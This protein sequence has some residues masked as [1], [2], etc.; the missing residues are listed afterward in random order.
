LRK[1]LDESRDQSY[2]LFGLTQDQLARTRF[3]LGGLRK[4]EVRELAHKLDVP[5]AKKGESREI[6]FVPNG[7]YARFV[8]LFLEKEGRGDMGMA[9][10]VVDESGNTLGDHG[11]V[12]RFTVGQRKG[13]G[14]ALGEPVY[15]TEIRP[16]TR[17]VV[18]GPKA[19]LLT[20][21]F[22]IERCNWIAFDE[23]TGP[24][25][26]EAKI[27]YQFK[28]VSVTVWPGGGSTAEAEFDEPQLAVTPG[29]AAVF[30]EG[31][32]VIGGGWILSAPR[33]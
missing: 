5:V 18:V 1:G 16:Y 31:D 11:G 32:V 2:F 14:V 7:D 15:V 4:K 22:R 3:P 21:R 20:Q 9:G 25:R 12:H 24:I 26:A 10:A 13:L 29:Q 23:L 28:P 17:E 6:C 30:Y 8:E 27:R 19:A 33:K